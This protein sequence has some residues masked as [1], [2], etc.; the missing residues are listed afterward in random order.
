M[1][2]T[3]TATVGPVLNCC[4]PL[5]LVPSLYK[6][7]TFL[8]PASLLSRWAFGSDRRRRILPTRVSVRWGFTSRETLDSRVKLSVEESGGE[9]DEVMVVD[10]WDEILGFTR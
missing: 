2:R 9:K 10:G 4:N 3:S 6:V 5:F 7:S 1:A 8:L